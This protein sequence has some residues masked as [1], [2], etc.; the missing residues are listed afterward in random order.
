VPNNASIFNPH[1]IAM[2]KGLYFTAVVFLLW[3]FSTPNL[4]GHRTDLHQTWTH[5]HLWLLFEKFG[6]N[7]LGH[8]PPRS[9]AKT[10]FSGPTLNFDRTY[11][12]NGTW[13]QQSERNLSIYRDSPTLA[14]LKLRPYGAIQMCILLLLLCPQIWWMLVHNRL[15]TVGEFCQPPKFSHWR[16]S[17]PYRMDVI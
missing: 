6:L 7:F 8:L 15:K 16:H 12:C 10:A 17:Q 5:I 13:Y 9:G 3:F 1:S 11:I 14:P 4:W 2:P